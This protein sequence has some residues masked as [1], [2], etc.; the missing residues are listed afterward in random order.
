MVVVKV[1]VGSVV[2]MPGFLLDLYTNSVLSLILNCLCFMI[3]FMKLMLKFRGGK[4]N[5]T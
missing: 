2:G 4:S 1:I 5:R 3:F